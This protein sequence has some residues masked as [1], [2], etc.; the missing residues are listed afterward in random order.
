MPQRF[1]DLGEQLRRA[2]LF[3]K[4]EDLDP[5]LLQCDLLPLFLI[6]LDMVPY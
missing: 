6:T 5:S 3:L 1:V 4:P 2:G